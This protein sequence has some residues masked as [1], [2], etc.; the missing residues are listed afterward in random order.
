MEILPVR[1]NFTFLARIVLAAKTLLL[2]GIANIIRFWQYKYY[3]I[4]RR[5][6]AE[7]CNGG[8]KV[9]IL[10]N[11]CENGQNTNRQHF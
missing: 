11:V 10:D 8:A 3:N 1:E 7:L 2:T 5:D 4:V 6:P 9:K